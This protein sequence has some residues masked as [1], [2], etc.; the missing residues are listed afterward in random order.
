MVA[1]SEDNS[2]NEMRTAYRLAQELLKD[3][4]EMVDKD[5][6]QQIKEVKG[7]DVIVV[8][9]RYDFIGN[10]LASAGIPFR[11]VA[12]AEV[13]RIMFRVDQTVFINCPGEI[14]SAGLLKVSEFVSGGGFLFTTDW[15]L[16]NVLEPAF[17]GYVRYNNRSTGDEVVRIELVASDDSF[18]KLLL[19]DQD[20]PQW[21]LESSSYPIE[22]MDEKRVKVMVSS[23]EIGRKYGASPVFVAFDYGNGTVYHMISHFYLQ[24][25]ETR[26]ERHMRPGAE[27]LNEKGIPA[28]LRAKYAAMG[29]EASKLA[30][31]E[32][33][34]TSTAM[35]NKVL[36]DRKKKR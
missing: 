33:A 25:S 13:E 19:S 36:F 12:P 21:W 26:T 2:G 22:I 3:R 17:P 16:R 35:M 34:F 24:R 7:D 11:Q 1:K 14:G 5:A 9:G 4:L 6:Y 30:D 20:D 18:L 32:S 10:V 23:K 8:D 31:V 28:A 27:Y 15:A 29:I